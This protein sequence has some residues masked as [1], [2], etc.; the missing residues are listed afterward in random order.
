[1]SDKQKITDS[2][3][4]QWAKTQS[5]ARFTLATSGIINYPLKEF[6]A[7]L[8]DLELSGPSSYGYEPLQQAL[9]EK[10]DVDP[11]CI[12]HA[13]GTSMANHL[14][15]AAILDRGDEVVIEQPAYDP[16]IAV[17]RY[18]GAGVKRFTRRFEEGFRINIR[19]IE[20]AVSTRTR[21]I[22]ITN[23]HNPT[24]ALTDAETLKQ[25]GE[26]ARKCGARVLVD[27]VYLEAIFD[28]ARPYAFH[29]GAE[30]VTTSSLTKAYGLSGLRCGWAVAEPTLA[31]K[32]WR[33][34]DLFGVIPAHPAE[35]LSVIALANL[36]QIAAR[37]KDL[38]ETNRP[39]LDHFL[40]SRDDIEAVRPQFGTVVSPRLK[41]GSVDALCLLLRE[42]YE[43]T[44]VPG[45]FFEMPEHFRIG[46]GCDTDM[47][48]AGLERLGAALDEQNK[49]AASI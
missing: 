18:L 34:N 21:L 30:F 8:A 40:D 44:V 22:V 26:I 43:T 37:A 13:T 23:M 42:K 17:A 35:R 14:A 1:M 20:R 24:G 12:I 46:I 16:L 49:T 36:K 38:L 45:H 27:E 31:K 4:M 39:L 47:L 41:R 25:I 19:E 9:A 3:Y 48:A 32:M 29:L 6:P 15:M 33:L 10:C 28:H 5:G 7:T 11:A 2:E